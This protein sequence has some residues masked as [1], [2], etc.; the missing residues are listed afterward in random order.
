MAIR[1]RLNSI[2]ETAQCADCP[3]GTWWPACALQFDHLPGEDKKLANVADLARGSS[4]VRIQTELAK[5]EV[6]CGNHHAIRTSWRRLAL[7]DEA[8]P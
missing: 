3:E 1:E 4:W 7:V 5:T 2:K 8:S 6:V